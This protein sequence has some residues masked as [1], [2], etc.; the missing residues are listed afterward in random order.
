MYLLLAA[1]PPS[2]QVSLG[3]ASTEHDVATEQAQ[4]AGAVTRKQIRCETCRHATLI[5][6]LPGAGF[7]AETRERFSLSVVVFLGG[8]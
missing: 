5:T 4:A 6:T 2:P 3:I 1:P 8:R 7:W